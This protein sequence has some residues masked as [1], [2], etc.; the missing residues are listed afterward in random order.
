MSSQDSPPDSRVFRGGAYLLLVP[1]SLAIAA[2][3][4][5]RH[6][7]ISS[8]P[9]RPPERLDPDST[10]D[11]LGGE[12]VLG[13]ATLAFWLA[14]F[15]PDAQRQAFQAG[16]LRRRY[17]LAEGE[18]W[19][20][21][22]EWRPLDAAQVGGQ[23]HKLDVGRLTIVDSAGLALAPLIQKH[24]IDPLATL[25]APPAR[26][27]EI[28]TSLDL[29]LWGRAPLSGARLVG[30]DDPATAAEAALDVNLTSRPLRLGDL[31]GPMAR[32]DPPAQPEGKRSATGASALP[33]RGTDDARY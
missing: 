4:W 1:F 22:L 28:G 27:L 21:R 23:G 3:W 17:G 12:T 19:R 10:H 25:L 13:G 30:L 29:F 7:P 11:V 2:V 5:V 14:P 31:A 32:L 9:T 18:A 24:G 6:P 8:V 20:L 26:P 16:A 33:V 15:E